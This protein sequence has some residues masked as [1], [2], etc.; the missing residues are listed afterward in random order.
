MDY[1]YPDK[2]HVRSWRSCL[3][4]WLGIAT[5]RGIDIRIPSASMLCDMW[6][7]N[8]TPGG[9]AGNGRIYG[10]HDLEPEFDDTETKFLKLKGWKSPDD[11]D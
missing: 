6:Y 3:E 8:H 2:N 9:A 4:F 7:R 10:F 1:N 5:Q 11:S